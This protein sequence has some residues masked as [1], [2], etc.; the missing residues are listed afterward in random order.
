MVF[1]PISMRALRMALGADAAS[2]RNM[3]LR[4]VGGLVLVGGLVGLAAALALG[5]LAQSLLYEIE[6][7]QP[8]VILAAVAVLGAVAFGA[9]YIPARRASRVNPMIAL[10]YE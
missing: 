10:R 4:Q 7:P 9:G 8:A 5:R 1:V 2:V 3:V 6:G